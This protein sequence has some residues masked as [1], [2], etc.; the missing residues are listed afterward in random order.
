M[1]EFSIYDATL[2][3][4]ELTQDNGILIE[5]FEPTMPDV[6]SV[7]NPRPAAHGMSDETRFYGGKNIGISGKFIATSSKTITEVSDA[8]KR[9]LM[10][11]KR[12][13]L[14]WDRDGVMKD[15]DVRL[16]K[17]DQSL[18]IVV[19]DFHVEWVCPSPFWRYPTLGQKEIP[20]SDS[21]TLG[22][23]P[24]PWLGT[25]NA[26][27]QFVAGTQAVIPV[28]NTGMVDTYPIF[29]IYGP[30]NG[31]T[32]RNV[33]TGQNFKI[34]AVLQQDH[35]LV[36][37]MYN[38][39]ATIDGIQNVFSL[40]DFVNSEWWSLAPGTQDVMFMSDNAQTGTP[41]AVITHYNLTV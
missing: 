38:H 1:A 41:F 7:T 28:E 33:T 22:G 25:D 24:W 14:R 5:K 19:D 12:P 37:D 27:I 16:E 32:L 3:W 30:V 10:P 18:F 2:G 26:V 9:Y 20:Y 29:T 36:I 8:F 11:N 13:V 40:I 34:A 21:V 6:R 17:A 31:V 39:T 15:I 4:L 23:D 35:V